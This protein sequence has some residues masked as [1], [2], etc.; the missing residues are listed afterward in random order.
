MEFRTFVC[1]CHLVLKKK[2][3]S[4]PV[5]CPV[6]RGGGKNIWTDLVRPS[7][8]AKLLGQSKNKPSHRTEEGTI[9]WHCRK[10]P[11]KTNKS[12]GEGSGVGVTDGGR[13]ESAVGP[14]P[15]DE[16]DQPPGRGV[17]LDRGQ[18]H[19]ESQTQQCPVTHG[20]F[21]GAWSVVM[22]CIWVG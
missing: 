17:L 3:G 5:F 19:P 1:A 18:A 16:A 21:R 8:S 12:E 10:A 20:H 4:F 13:G 7:P 9:R 11:K 14:R 2:D 15:R 22:F 6:K